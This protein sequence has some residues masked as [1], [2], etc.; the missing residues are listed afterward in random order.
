[1]QLS[2]LERAGD[3][4]N[5]EMD[6]GLEAYCF[7]RKTYTIGKVVHD[8]NERFSIEKKTLDRKKNTTLKQQHYLNVICTISLFT[9]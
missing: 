8:R 5:V 6:V 1:M 2:Q 3:L 7:E 9:Y 4:I